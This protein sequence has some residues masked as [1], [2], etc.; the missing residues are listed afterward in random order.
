M[1]KIKAWQR[2]RKLALGVAFA[3]GCSMAVGAS[4][5]EVKAPI[6]GDATVDTAFADYITSNSSSTTYNFDKDI[7]IKV[8]SE[9]NA[10]LQLTVGS[11]S[12]DI[13]SGIA[14]TKTN[15]NYLYLNPKGNTITVDVIA[16]GDTIGAGIFASDA[17]QA[18]NTS[19][20]SS[21]NYNITVTGSADNTQKSYGIWRA[22]TNTTSKTHYINRQTDENADKTINI[23]VKNDN[24]G[25]GIAFSTPEGA[26]K[27]TSN[28]ST[29]SVSGNVNVKV[30]ENK[31]ANGLLD[32]SAGLY[33]N[34]KNGKLTI[35]GKANLD[36][37][38]NGIVLDSEPGSSKIEVTK[39]GTI[40]VAPSTDGS[41]RYAIYDNGG[42]VYFGGGAVGGLN[43]YK[44]A[45]AKGSGTQIDG[46]IFLGDS[47]ETVLWLALSGDD[48]YLKGAIKEAGAFGNV[49]MALNDGAVWYNSAAN[50]VNK[51]TDTVITKIA[52]N[53]GT[54]YQG[55]DSGN[56]TLQDVWSNSLNIAYEHDKADPSKILGGSVT[57]EKASA[58]NTLNVFTDYDT[59]MNTAS[60]RESVLNALAN[61]IYYTGYINGEDKIDGYVS[62]AEGLTTSAA[63]KYLA[64]MSFDKTTGQGYLDKD[65]EVKE[66]KD[67]G[68]QQ[69]AEFDKAILGS[70]VNKAYYED[71]GVYK[72]GVYSFT[73]DTAITPENN[74]VVAG[75]WLNKFASGIFSSYN[76]E[77]VTVDMNGKKL[78]LKNVTD[79]STTGMAAVGPTG[80]V[81][82]NNAGAMD[83][84]AESTAGSQTA[85]LF[86]NGGGQLFIHNGGEDGESKVLTLHGKTMNS[87][88]GAVVKSMNGAVG[89]RSWL[90]VD[91]LVDIEADTTDGVGMAEGLS[92][93]ASTI[94][95]G[96]G[97]II[98]SAAG[99]NPGLNFGDN[100][101]NCA[102]RAYGEFVTSNRG[103]VNVNVIK[104]EDTATGKAIAA[105][106]NRTQINGNFNTVG[107]MGTKGTINVGLNTADSYWIGNY[108]NGAGW[109]MTPGD[110]GAVNLFMG[111]GAQWKG[112][113]KFATN[114]QMDSGATW[115]GFSL[116]K[117]VSLTLKNGAT[118]YN[119]NNDTNNSADTATTLK[120]IKG[121]ASLAEAGF[122]DMTADGVRDTTV[123]DYSGYTKV[124][125]KRDAAAPTTI[126]GGNFTVVSAEKGSYISML[127]DSDGLGTTESKIQEALG[128]LANK[129]YYTGATTGEDN[130]LSFVSINDGLKGDSTQKRVGSVSFDATTGQGQL[131]W[132]AAKAQTKLAYDEAITGDV[133]NDINYVKDGVLDIDSKEYNFTKTNTMLT[134]DSHNIAGGP[135]VS[136]IAAAISGADGTNV[137]LNLNDKRLTVNG[138]GKSHSTGIAAIGTGTVEV[139]NA[140]AMSITANGGG[141]T[142]A[143]FANGGG[144]V[145]IHNGDGDLEKKVLTARANATNKANGAVI[146]T[147]NGKNGVTSHITIDG[148][149]DVLADGINSNEAVSAVASTID[150]GGGR[151][152]AQGDSWAAIRAYGEFVSQN[153]GTVNFNVEKDADGKV[154]GAGD[155]RAVVIG[156][157]VTNGGMGTRGQVNLGF[158]GENSYWEGNYAD[159][160]GYGVTPEQLGSVNVFLED[161]AHWKGF[162]NGSMNV[163]LDGAKTNWY[164]FNTSD[165]L[166]LTLTN[167]AT[168]YNAITSEQKD[169]KDNIVSAKVGYLKSDNGFID[170]T[171]DRVFTTESKSLSGSTTQGKASSITESTNGI[172]G[173]VVVNNY[174]G[175]ATVF[176]KHVTD[177]D[178]ISISGG[179]F[180][181][182]NAAAGSKITLSTD[183]D[184]IDV[185]N[186][187]DVRDALGGLA[188]KLFYL[189]YVDGERN[190]DGYVQIA[191]GLTTRSAAMRAG[192]VKFDETTGQGSYDEGSLKPEI[193]YPTFQTDVAYSDAVTGDIRKDIEYVKTG[194]LNTETGKYNF[195][196]N[197][198]LDVAN[199][200]IAGGPWVAA[201]GAAIS[202]A[203]G[204]N[205][206]IDLNGK[207]M[208]INA[209]NKGHSTGISAINSGIVE[210]ANA[211][212][213]KIT[214]EGTGQTAAIFANGGGT[215]I[216]H[217]GDGDLEKKVL[218]VRANASNKNNGAVIKT[219]NGKNGATS[220]ITI[221]GLVDV[222]ADGVNSNEAVSAVAS[223]IDIGGGRIEAQG[224]AWAAIRAYGEFVSQNV[225]TVN[226]NVVKD[227]DGKVI[228]AGDKR[229]VVI[230]D[231]VTNGGMGTRGQ[232]SMG[233]KGENSY[234][235]GNYADNVGYGVTPDQLGSV[236]V[237]LEDGAHW[238]GF[239]NG[240]MNV[241]LDGAKT[242][243]YGF[244][245]SEKLALTLKNGATWY[246]AITAD[247]TDT[248]GNIVSAKVGYL[249]SDNGFIDMTGDRVFKAEGKSLSGSTTQGA[250]SW[251]TES[252]NGITGD[253]V[254]DNFAGNVTV[255]YGHEQM[256]G[257]A[258]S[259]DIIGGNFT[260]KSAAEGSKIT[261]ST[262][263]DGIDTSNPD[264][265][266]DILSKLANKLI[267]TGAAEGTENNL[268]GFVQIAEGLTSSSAALKVGS[269]DF[270][271]ENG[272]GSLQAGSIV[273]PDNKKNPDVIYGDKETA[274]MKGAK[275]A[276]ASSALMWRAENNDLMKRMGD[277]R[278]AE[279]E[280]GIW[281]KYYGGKYSMDGQNTDLSMKYNA[282]QVGYDK[283]VGNGWLAGVALSYNDGS[284]SYGS[285]RADLKGTS[286]GVYGTWK[287]DDGQYVDLIAKY[288]RLEN[289][290]DVRNTYGHKLSGDYK[291]WGA[292]LSAEYGKRFEMD[293]GF[294]VDPSVE[295]TL[296]RVAAKDYTAGSDYL[297]ALGKNRN[298]S[299]EQDAFTSF[300]GRVGVRLG[301]KTDN[302]SYF[303]KLAAA[304]EF[305][306]DFDSTFR[307]EGEADGRTSIDFGDTWYEAQLGGSV[308]LNDNSMVYA[309]FERSFGGDVEQ[310]WRVDAGLRWSF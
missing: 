237:F 241:Q 9:A 54:I 255:I 226:F 17:R 15:A 248:N 137:K 224:D 95:I 162:A 123:D 125:Y 61:K 184:G 3:L 14:A 288:S 25:Y 52:G 18:I 31:K 46:D 272:Q 97:R 262:D 122:I 92:A 16:H 169:N 246:N 157:V 30:S 297:D 115:E 166:A 219:M 70:T 189:G 310:K 98:M 118:W 274:M 280:S 257:S 43:G 164:G 71:A 38:G 302:A 229:A 245:T 4:A 149:V 28:T 161:G 168:W 146:K 290:F 59:N 269:I 154:I 187:F 89:E 120:N 85:A 73:K 5:A 135:W 53:N 268:D 309:S 2:S 56:V 121:G 298:L 256:D 47:A 1:K 148:L 76:D 234:W 10:P 171:G 155:K 273:T 40:R 160:V 72:D 276:M 190:L 208:E 275:T 143:I 261:M 75:P 29:L 80:K 62:I 266:Q 258:G 39:G 83:I 265:L 264:E 251:I 68:E 104:D 200:T 305:S 210:I 20:D 79:Q 183:N 60:V 188:Q 182:K 127:T 213:M 205:V 145:T 11:N 87:T 193:K 244:N 253:V 180:T 84:Y 90:K 63:T 94:E 232:V 93:V 228:G 105:G 45:V 23:T 74:S 130:I 252:E 282:Y 221:D 176:Y 100:A 179:N 304:H 102:I 181:I 242:N 243:W 287:C 165:K 223:T 294:Y 284:S 167:G 254:V 215:L 138:I 225:G 141:Q 285:G 212:A 114:V 227:A 13:I 48:A 24:G 267:Y 140:G 77:A 301:Q 86:V 6:T 50:A 44:G 27:V 134:V 150:I 291:T 206:Q 283:E 132:V 133:V 217:N 186:I 177:K 67:A 201:I 203:D 34:T 196:Q 216:I 239:G 293:K 8:D 220:H 139:N 33:V 286:L 230:G 191:E 106:N 238:K 235:E 96:G 185:D 192:D 49:S 32:N 129:L 199:N 300:I 126:L 259:M 303:V 175:N 142:A 281:A 240:S 249:T 36:V 110:Y 163:Q 178:G 295:L 236:N 247:Q 51:G 197:T 99:V 19:T 101:T 65:T 69:Q 112:Y 37:A 198:K 144:Q 82:I 64:D 214:A 7:T 35:N 119:N 78:T 108:I 107:G 173:D 91:G 41:E 194:V 308:K 152:E 270:S 113:S 151:I 279:G 204:T 55:A 195:T 22:V 263:N 172:T 211:G 156:D 103:I 117:A 12:Y 174:E 289:E 58:D 307:A 57:I 170:M 26:D 66:A 233:F 159:N 278:L 88:N 42:I 124:I 153:V 218:T 271:A 231:V 207:D 116:N 222:L 128:N 306:G 250:A 277:L 131:D 158:K 292:S 296:G 299:V 111:N 202:G 109:G 21:G 209:A 260:I 147:M 81:E 136:S